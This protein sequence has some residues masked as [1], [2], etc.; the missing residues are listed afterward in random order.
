[1]TVALTN[2]PIR[3]SVCS[4]EKQTW[5]MKYL[6]PWLACGLPKGCPWLAHALPDYRGVGCT[7][8]GCSLVAAPSQIER[9]C[10]AAAPTLQPSGLR[11][12]SR[13]EG[14]VY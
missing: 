7:Q 12:F 10:K 5:E 1:M 13:K 2:V 9:G 8:P 6:N 11:D 4:N 3:M 14:K